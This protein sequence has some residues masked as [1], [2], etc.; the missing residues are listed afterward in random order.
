MRLILLLC[1]VLPLAA[2]FESK[3]SIISKTEPLTI[4]DSLGEERVML[5][6]E[7][8]S[9]P[10][11]MRRGLMFRESMG[12]D[13]GMLFDFGGAEAERGFWM[14]NTLI[15]LDMLFIKADGTVH[16][17]HENAI[18]HDLTSIRSNG[19]VA[20]VLEINGGLSQKLGIQKGDKVKHTV[21]Q[22]K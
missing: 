16:H 20:A 15:P 2:C 13:T 12:D 9:Q 18:P 8:V 14:K 21:F 10:E 11:E 7:V 22:L 6:V 1:F 17:I 5:H 4:L 3:E 19:S